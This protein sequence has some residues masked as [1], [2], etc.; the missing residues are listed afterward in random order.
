MMNRTPEPL[1]LLAGGL[2]LR[3]G[4]PKPLL[5]Y[6]G[7]TL[8]QRLAAAAQRPVWLAAAGQHFDGVAAE[9]VDD[10]LPERQGPLSAIGAGLLRA[11]AQAYAGVYVMACDTLLLPEMLIGQL[12]QTRAQHP[13]VCGVTALYDAAEA[14]CYPLLAYWPVALADGLLGY[15]QQGGRRV[16]DCV[17]DSRCCPMPE[18]WR[19]WVNFNTPEAFQAAVTAWERNQEPPLNG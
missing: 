12:V 5:V 14:R 17:G 3:M 18:A 2:S 1:L 16:M 9:A 4:Q 19:V 7:Q 6:R 15:L 13:E 11:R 10:A 8:V